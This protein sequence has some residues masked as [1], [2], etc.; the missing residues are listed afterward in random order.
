MFSFVRVNTDNLNLVPGKK[1]LKAK[2]YMFYLE[3]E[4][5][6]EAAKEKADQIII[7][8]KMVYEEEKK[9][10]YQ[11]GL[12][13]SKG[14]SAKIIHE[15]IMSCNKY[16]L[17]A[18]KSIT[19]AVLSCVKMIHKNFDD[20][21]GTMNIVKESLKH[22]SNQKQITLHVNEHEVEKVR[23]QINDIL[24]SFPEI[25]FIDVIAD[26][27]LNNGGCILE[28]EVGIIDASLD[29]QLSVLE[30]KIEKMFASHEYDVNKT[31]DN[32]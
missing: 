31:A 20:V 5:L 30:E 6:I 1:I 22:V 12:E 14:E 9:R 15:T 29:T 32:V 3:S 28:T 18:E 17:T 7:E 8:A 25:G 10:G 27:R 13:E 4:H 23:K 11:D 21:E 16:Y 2:D 26:L 19:D 24:S